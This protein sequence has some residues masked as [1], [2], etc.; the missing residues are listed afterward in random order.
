MKRNACSPIPN[1]DRRARRVY[2]SVICVT[3]N[4]LRVMSTVAFR[5][6]L[7]SVSVATTE[8]WPDAGVVMLMVQVADP[9]NSVGAVKLLSFFK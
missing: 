2:G 5:V 8:R 7:P 6:L 9:V 4:G 3:A 1:G